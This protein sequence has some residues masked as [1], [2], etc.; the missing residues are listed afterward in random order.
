M[1]GFGL[2]G[3]AA[4]VLFLVL[5][6]K[7][8]SHSLPGEKQVIQPTQDINQTDDE[9]GV[10]QNARVSVFKFWAGILLATI[11]MTLIA[12][13]TDTDSAGKAM[14]L[15]AILLCLWIVGCLLT[16]PKAV[17]FFKISHDLGGSFLFVGI[18]IVS[19]VIEIILADVTLAIFGR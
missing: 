17:R 3:L 8:E 7:N 2:M 19:G 18:A 9:S 15:G 14:N 6:R 10:L 4:I 12:S 16:L 5:N 13:R 1:I 11:P